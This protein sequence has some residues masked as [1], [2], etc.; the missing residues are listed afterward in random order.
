MIDNREETSDSGEVKGA[1]TPFFNKQEPSPFYKHPEPRFL[2]EFFSLS[3]AGALYYWYQNLPLDEERG[4]QQPLEVNMFNFTDRTLNDTD[5][6]SFW[7]RSKQ[8]WK[9]SPKL[10]S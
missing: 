5:T 4:F 7:V 6:E 3:A 8:K 1:G 2:P 10:L 9:V